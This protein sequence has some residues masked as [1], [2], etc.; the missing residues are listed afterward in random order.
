MA[1]L[2]I[3]CKCVLLLSIIIC[4]TLAP[5]EGRQIASRDDY[6]NYDNPP[7]MKEVGIMPTSTKSSVHEDSG[8]EAAYDK[9]GLQP[10]RTGGSPGIGH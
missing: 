1:E 2:Q 6:A 9:D 8:A 10:P 4:H 7:V 5:L 3:L